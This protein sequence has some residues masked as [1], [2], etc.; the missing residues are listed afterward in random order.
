MVRDTDVIRHDREYA[1]GKHTTIK[2]HKRKCK[3]DES[4]NYDPLSDE[5]VEKLNERRWTANRKREEPIPTSK[6]IEGETYYLVTSFR[7]H[8]QALH[9]SKSIQ[10]RGDYAQVIEVQ[11]GKKKFHAVYTRKG[12]GTLRSR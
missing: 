2:H 3:T 1:P 6:N 8:G 5:F 11:R 4:Q 10:R 9:L 12:A 7:N